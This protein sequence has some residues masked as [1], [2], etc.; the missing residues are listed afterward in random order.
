MAE[1]RWYLII[2]AV[3][4]VMAL[5]SSLLKRLPLSTSIFY[6]LIG[7]GIGP[8]GLR[9]LKVDPIADAPLIERLSEAAALVSLFTAGL[10]LRA[11]L[12]DRRWLVPVRLATVSMLLTVGLIA[13]A[14]V[15]GLGLSLG[16]AV[17]LGAILGPTDPVLA[18][19][20]QVE[21]PSD[22]DRVR[23]GLTGEAGLNDGS[24][25]PLVL[26]GLGLLD[27]HNLGRLG[28]SWLALDLLWAVG[29]GL[30]IGWLLGQG[31]GRLVLRLRR[32]R[33]AAIGLDDFLAL[34]LIALSGGAASLVHA[35]SFLAVFAAGLAMRSIELR[36][37]AGRPAEEALQMSARIGDEERAASDPEEAPA[38]MAQAML[39]FNEQL[40]RIGEV[41]L[42]VLVGVLLPTVW[43]D[44][45]AATLWFIPLLF[46]VVRPLAVWVGLLGRRLPRIQRFLISWFG[47]RG[48]GSIYYLM[49][50][51]THGLAASLARPLAGLVLVTIVASIVA[52]GVSVTPL[53]R[54]YREHPA[55]ASG[56]RAAL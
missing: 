5:G 11:K 31:I 53:M 21:Q 17:L 15:L 37:N 51:I 55:G 2:G 3:F 36:E 46:L 20:V 6:L 28:G 22:G 52:H 14:G 49:Y 16:A 9:L 4:M 35:D 26:L 45:P 18:S 32:E 25:Y 40:E 10:K 27:L 38:Y 12:S 50:A 29:G 13:L 56:Q 48:I 39:T 41:A 30:G 42:V 1:T 7:L 34:G 19:D 23:F 47:I 43:A 24:A 8:L 33:R 54:R 44:V